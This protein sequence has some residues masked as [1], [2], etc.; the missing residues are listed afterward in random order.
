M[1]LLTEGSRTH[2]F[3]CPVGLSGALA[4]RSLMIEVV[5][6]LR[7]FGHGMS[8]QDA[9]REAGLHLRD[10]RI[11]CLPSCLVRVAS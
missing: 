1:Q 8:P 11:A 2:C 3:A 5:Y 4:Q 7:V 9:D 6:R 10:S